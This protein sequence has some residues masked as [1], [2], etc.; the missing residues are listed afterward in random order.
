MS[1]GIGLVPKTPVMASFSYDV[2]DKTVKKIGSD[3]SSKLLSNQLVSE[4]SSEDHKILAEIFHAA[5]IK[6]LDECDVDAIDP[7]D[8]PIKEIEEESLMVEFKQIFPW[9]LDYYFSIDNTTETNC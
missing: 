2:T 3:C 8:F 4:L 1:L 6:S 5:K 7:P 9:S